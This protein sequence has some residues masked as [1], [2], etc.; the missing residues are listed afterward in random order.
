MEGMERRIIGHGEMQV[1]HVII[2]VLAVDQVMDLPVAVAGE[3][4]KA[5]DTVALLAEV[6]AIR[7]Y[8][9][10][11]SFPP[12]SDGDGKGTRTRPA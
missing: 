4:Q 1:W 8:P 11:V 6:V 10:S 7:P 9:P 5:S 12:G 3:I 2:L